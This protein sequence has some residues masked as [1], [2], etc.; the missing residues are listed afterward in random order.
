MIE[1]SEDYNA[2]KKNEAS[3]DQDICKNLP[4]N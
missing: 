3:E 4:N 2:Y 1:V